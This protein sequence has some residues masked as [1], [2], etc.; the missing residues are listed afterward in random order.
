M[1]GCQWSCVLVRA[2]F[3]VQSQH[4]AV[5]SHSRKGERSLRILLYKATH[6]IH[7]VPPL[8]PKHHRRP[9]VLVPSSLG[10]GFQHM[11]FEEAQN[12]FIGLV[13]PNGITANWGGH[14]SKWPREAYL[15]KQLH[16]PQ[17]RQGLGFWMTWTVEEVGVQEKEDDPQTQSGHLSNLVSLI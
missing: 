8:W 3:L 5:S 10:F 15:E 12:L 4:L 7:E 1:S 11:N 6:L 17:C 14:I 16:C 13:I 9:H 2:L